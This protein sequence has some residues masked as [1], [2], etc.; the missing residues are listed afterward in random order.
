MNPLII[1]VMSDLHIGKNAR[2]SDLCPKHHTSRGI[3]KDYRNRFKAFVKQNSIKADYLIVPGDI[4]DQADPDQ[5]SLASE[6][7]IEFAKALHLTRKKIIFAPGNHDVDWSV[8]KASADK[9][10]FRKKQRYAPLKHSD[11]IFEKVMKFF[12]HI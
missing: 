4:T 5:M 10:G 2:S 11:W 8:L 7:L 3:D 6:V 12:Y 9:T 1:A